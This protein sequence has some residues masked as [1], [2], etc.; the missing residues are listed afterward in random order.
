MWLYAMI[1]HL[2]I[3]G[4][5]VI[6]GNEGFAK[7][8]TDGDTTAP[9]EK[10]GDVKLEGPKVDYFIKLAKGTY[11]LV[12]KPSQEKKDLSTLVYTKTKS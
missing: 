11:L 10:I 6:L 4:I 9:F 8:F 3:Q 5:S 7:W 12:K 2:F 1:I